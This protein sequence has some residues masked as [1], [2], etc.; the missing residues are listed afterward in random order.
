MGRPGER[1]RALEELH[2]AI[3]LNPG[4]AESH[5]DLGK[6]ELESGD[7]ATA[8]SELETAVRL[9]PNSER[10][11]GELADAYKAV[12]RPADA[13]KE[14]ETCDLLKKQ[15]RTGDSSHQASAPQQ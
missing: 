4:D 12:L 2:T 7:T 11:H 1:Q 8:I 5:Y 15:L 3:Q 10:Y 9:S 6:I 14:M 13:Q